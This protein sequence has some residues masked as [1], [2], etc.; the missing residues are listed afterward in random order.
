M[1]VVLINYDE[2]KKP[3]VDSYGADFFLLQC[4]NGVQINSDE[5]KKPYIDS[6][7]HVVGCSTL[8]TYEIKKE[9]VAVEPNTIFFS[10]VRCS[11]Q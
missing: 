10:C 1:D 2:T 3:Y 8:K 6:Y 5:T 9:I 7:G 11:I 4:V